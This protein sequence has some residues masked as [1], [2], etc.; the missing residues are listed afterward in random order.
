MVNNIG[1]TM[2]IIKNIHK[3]RSIRQ[4]NNNQIS[5]NDINTIL[6]A[7]MTAPS[8]MNKQPWRFILITDEKIKQE[9][10]KISKYAQMMLQS[11]FSVLVCGDTDASYLDYW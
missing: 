11:P 10:V 6:S 4:F 8:A 2:E 7:G 9:V 1:Y 5:E 3:R